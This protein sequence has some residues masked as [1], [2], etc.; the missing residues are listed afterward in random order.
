MKILKNVNIQVKQCFK[1]NVWYAGKMREKIGVTGQKLYFDE[2]I[3][4]RKDLMHFII[5]EILL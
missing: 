3:Y 2:V 5:Q 1:D 4:L